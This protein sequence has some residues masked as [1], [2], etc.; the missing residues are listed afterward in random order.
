MLT[1]VEAKKIGIQACMDKIGY[2]FC[3]KHADNGTTAYGEDD[4]FVKCFLGLVMSRR[5]I[6]I[7]K[8][9]TI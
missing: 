4:G 5:Q 3:K 8:K 9:W 7:L 2:D 6:M 1:V